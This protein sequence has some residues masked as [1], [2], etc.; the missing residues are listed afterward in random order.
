MRLFYSPTSPYARKARIVARE[1]GLLTEIE[2]VACD[3]W[4]DPAELRAINPLGR[5]P[6][7]VARNGAHLFDSPVICAYLN[8]LVPAPA[9]IPAGDAKWA[10][11]AAEALADGTIDTAVNLVL[12]G[13]RP[14][15]ERS[16]KFMARWLEAIGRAAA[17]LDAARKGLPDALT[18]GHIAIAV[19]LSYLDFRLPQVNWREGRGALAEWHQAFAARPAMLETAPPPS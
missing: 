16:A 19:A 15:A 1:K 10:V 11:L 4:A 5:V 3:P 18:Q 7:L 13:R 12:E 17:A 2:E 8:D 6:A 9:L 14:E